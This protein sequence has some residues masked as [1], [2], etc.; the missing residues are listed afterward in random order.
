MWRIDWAPSMKKNVDIAQQIPAERFRIQWAPHPTPYV[1][2][3]RP[4]WLLAVVMSQI[5]PKQVAHQIIKP[6][7]F[8]HHPRA[9]GPNQSTL[10]YMT[11]CGT[12]VLRSSNHQTKQKPST[13]IKKRHPTTSNQLN[14]KH[15]ARKYFYD[16]ENVAKYSKLLLNIFLGTAQAAS[17]RFPEVRHGWSPSGPCHI[18]PYGLGPWIFLRN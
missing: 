5:S 2:K 16:Y 1:F 7:S 3:Q 18:R 12:G 8:S 10:S 9:S 6:G 14:K 15:D 4:Q 13:T 11:N 17:A